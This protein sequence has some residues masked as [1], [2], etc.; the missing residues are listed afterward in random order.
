MIMMIKILIIMLITAIISSILTYLNYKTINEKIN[1]YI[2]KIIYNKLRQAMK[3]K[4][5]GSF[6]DIFK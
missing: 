3:N 1:S 2:S 4:E 6:E 5:G